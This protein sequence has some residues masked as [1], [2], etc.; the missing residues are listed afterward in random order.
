MLPGRRRVSAAI[1]VLAVNATHPKEMHRADILEYTPDGKF[2]QIYAAGIRNPVGLAINPQ[3]GASS[4]RSV[5]SA[6]LAITGADDIT[7]SRRA[8]STVAGT[9]WAPIRIH[10][11][12]AS[13]PNSRI[14]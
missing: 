8:A 11:W 5:R 1:V 4:R 6:K 9:T 10:G 7:T 3:T 2:V 13:T 14:R 12:K